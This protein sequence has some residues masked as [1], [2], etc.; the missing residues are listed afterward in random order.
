MYQYEK[1]KKANAIV[2]AATLLFCAGMV[3]IAFLMKKVENGATILNF[4]EDPKAVVQAL[5]IILYGILWLSS[6]KYI[7]VYREI[8]H[9]KK[10][11]RIPF[12]L[13]S[14]MLLG[15]I[16]YGILNYM[17]EEEGRDTALHIIYVGVLFALLLL[18]K[19]LL[20]PVASSAALSVTAFGFL[21]ATGYHIPFLMVCIEFITGEINL[22][23]EYALSFVIALGALSNALSAEKLADVM[24]AYLS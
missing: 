11:L 6:I 7:I 5:E 21:H 4:I 17:Y 20:G 23:L 9:I 3:A 24:D 2:V 15:C 13:A 19:G 12:M 1:E 22:Q 10:R 8:Y 14:I 16:A 18:L